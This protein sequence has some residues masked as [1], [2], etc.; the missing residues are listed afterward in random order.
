MR[1]TPSD[2]RPK[3]ERHMVSGRP[4]PRYEAVTDG[5]AVRVVPRFMHDESSPVR[6]KFFWS[7]M[8]EIENQ[9]DQAWTLTHRHWRIVDVAGRQQEVDG[10]G[11]VGQTPRLEPGESFRY[12]SGAP[13][14]APSGIMSGHYRF[15]NDAGVALHAVIPAF[16]LDSP[17]DRAQPS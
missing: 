10:E 1:L 14:S 5:I 11:V 4:S 6:G 7:Y 2:T 17:Y 9:S 12:T 3:S 13:L 15:E 8:V 16:S